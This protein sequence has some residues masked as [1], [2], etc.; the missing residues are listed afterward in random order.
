[1]MLGLALLVVGLVGPWVLTT[2]V[3][4]T[5]SPKIYGGFPSGASSNP[6]LLEPSTSYTLKASVTPVDYGN[7]DPLKATVKVSIPETGQ[8]LTLAYKSKAYPAWYYEYPGWVSPG[9]GTSLT[10]NW[11]VA[12]QYGAT[13]SNVTYATTAPLGDGYFTVA[14]QQ[15]TSTT[16]KVVVLTNTFSVTFTKTRDPITEVWF[17]VQDSAGNWKYTKADTVRTSFPASW[18]PTLADGTYDIRGYFTS[19]GQS[20]QVMSLFGGINTEPTPFFPTPKDSFYWMT[21]AGA[22]LIVVGLMTKR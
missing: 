9:P 18:N 21:I 14:G 6:T 7:D 3:I 10:F 16:D 5:G 17:V 20:V 22:C 11:S 19:Y 12:D 2:L 1:M 4:R 8:T 15:I 13:G